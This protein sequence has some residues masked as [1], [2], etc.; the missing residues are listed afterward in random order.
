MRQALHN[1]ADVTERVLGDAGL[2]RR[3]YPAD[4]FD[5]AMIQALRLI[6]AE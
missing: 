6:P 3:I 4:L 1:G 2:L 5:P